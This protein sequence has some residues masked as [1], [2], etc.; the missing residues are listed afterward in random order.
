MY[1]VEQSLEAVVKLA[2]M[3]SACDGE[4]HPDENLLIHE[5]IA[6]KP[7]VYSHC[8]NGAFNEAMRVLKGTGYVLKDSCLDIAKNIHV[9]LKYDAMELCLHIAQA[10]G[11]GA[12]DEMRFLMSIGKWLDLDYDKFREMRD[13]ILPSTIHENIDVDTQ[14]GLLPEMSLAEKKKHLREEF[15]KWNPLSEHKDPEIRKQAKERLDLIGQKRAEL[16]N[17]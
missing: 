10:D 9:S 2:V 12:D 14:L 15:K 5:W 17:E 8:M 6:G 1:T 3:T 7:A 4:I 13:K 11:V 16:K